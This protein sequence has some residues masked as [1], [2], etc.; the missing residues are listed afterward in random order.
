MEKIVFG[1]RGSLLQPRRRR[2]RRRKRRIT[3]F[4]PPFSKMVKSNIAS[5]FLNIIDQCFPERDTS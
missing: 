5:T 4:N 1:H 3:W 2:R